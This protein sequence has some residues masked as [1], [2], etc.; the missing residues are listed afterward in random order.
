MPFGGGLHQSDRQRQG[1]HDLS[2]PPYNVPIAGH[3]SGLGNV[4]HREFAM[5]SGEMS[6]EE[7]TAFLT[8]ACSNMATAPVDGAIAFICMDWRHMEEM[9]AAGQAAFTQFKNLIVWVKDNG[10]MGSFYRGK[11]ELVVAYKIG[12][13]T[14]IN[15]FELGQHGRYRTNVWS[16]K[17]M[18][19]F[20]AGRNDGSC[21]SS[22]GE[23]RR[24]DRRCHR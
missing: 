6:K 2:N 3:V 15:S 1:P 14:H 24:D 12:T 7:F 5:A 22:H 17:G 23:A 19:S 9:G 21:A 16:Y 11:H 8:T 13:A 18:N 4:Q 10:G 20:G